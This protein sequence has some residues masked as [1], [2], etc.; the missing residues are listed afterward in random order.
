MYDNVN[1]Y[2]LSYWQFKFY[3]QSFPIDITTIRAAIGS[4]GIDIN[5]LHFETYI[6]KVRELL[7]KQ[8]DPKQM[9]E[10]SLI[11]KHNFKQCLD[12]DLY[13]KK[14]VDTKNK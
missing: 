9:N 1:I 4:P 8:I 2:N 3:Q 13:V 6:L 12:A 5:N 7:K 11:C 14:C 10:I